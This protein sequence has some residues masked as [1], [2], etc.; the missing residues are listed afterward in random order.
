VSSGLCV[1]ACEKITLMDKKDERKENN[2]SKSKSN[3]HVNHRQRHWKQKKEAKKSLFTKSAPSATKNQNTSRGKSTQTH[4]NK[5]EVC[6]ACICTH[7]D[8]IFD[9]LY[10]KWV[11]RQETHAEITTT[12]HK[13]TKQTQAH[14]RWKRTN[15]HFCC[16]LSFFHMNVH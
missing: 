12:M 7:Q 11:V 5:H 10:S 6:V 16:R 8:F 3:S 13:H 2:T 4:S 9:W 1:R 14:N 15:V